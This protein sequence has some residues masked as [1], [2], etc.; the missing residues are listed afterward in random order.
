M[1]CSH[2]VRRRFHSFTLFALACLSLLSL[3]SPACATE[4]TIDG[5]GQAI[6]NYHTPE[7]RGPGNVLHPGSSAITIEL[8]WDVWDL[9]YQVVPVGVRLSSASNDNL[10]AN[11][12]GE[13]DMTSGMLYGTLTFQGGTGRFTHASGEATLL[14]MFNNWDNPFSTSFADWYLEGTID[15]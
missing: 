6:L 7:I 3:A 9:A 2:V 5:D 1:F 8:D 14:L 15:Y 4:R 11:F 12:D 13:F 10:Y